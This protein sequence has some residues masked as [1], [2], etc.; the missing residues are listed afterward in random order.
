MPASGLQVSSSNPLQVG[1]SDIQ[2]PLTQQEPVFW[3]TPVKRV[4]EALVGL[5]SWGSGLVHAGNNAENGL[6]HFLPGMILFQQPLDRPVK[7]RQG[8]FQTRIAIGKEAKGPRRGVLGGTTAIGSAL[9][10]NGT[11]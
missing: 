1:Q 5:T 10:P 4:K 2:H 8:L 9:L 3:C 11:M 6:L 7:V